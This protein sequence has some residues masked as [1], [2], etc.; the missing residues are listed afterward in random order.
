MRISTFVLLGAVF[1][2]VRPASPCSLE[3]PVPAPDILVRTADVIVRARAEAIVPGPPHP[4][5]PAGAPTDVRF[6][7]LEVLKGSVASGPLGF[8]GVAG[9][10]ND[11]NDHPVP[12]SF[13]RPGGRRGNCFALEYWIGAEYLLLL[14]RTEPRSPDAG[15]LTPYWAAL[16]PVNEQLFGGADDPWCVWVRRELGKQKVAHGQAP[17]GDA[18]QIE[19]SSREASPTCPP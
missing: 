4:V 2:P 8:S 6:T 13:V 17:Q 18:R 10:R 5:M 12:Y 1:I 3:A 11:P 7:V 16:G 15:N 9:T 14:K 19:P